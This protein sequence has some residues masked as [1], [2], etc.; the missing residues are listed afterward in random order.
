MYQHF[1]PHGDILGQHPFVGVMADTSGTAQEEHRHG[2]HRGHHAGIMAGA[3]DQ[4]V[5]RMAAGGQGLSRAS[6]RGPDRP[7]RPSDLLA[8]ETQERHAA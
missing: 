3:A 5:G 4:T 2:C 6:R 1:E 7:E 8:Y